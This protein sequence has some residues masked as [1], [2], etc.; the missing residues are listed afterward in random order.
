MN[1]MLILSFFKTKLFYRIANR[2]KKCCQS[3]V[4][5]PAGGI[6][7]LMENMVESFQ[8]KPDLPQSLCLLQ[9]AF[10]AKQATFYMLVQAAAALI[11]RSLVICRLWLFAYQKTGENC[12]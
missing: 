4:F 5:V 2:R 10:L 11:I 1:L 9:E 6:K 7:Y 12:E 8:L 3:S